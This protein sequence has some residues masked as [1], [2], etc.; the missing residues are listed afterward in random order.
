MRLHT[1]VIAAA[2]SSATASFAAERITVDQAVQMALKGTR[3]L[4]SV[5]K[6]AGWSHDIALSTGARLL[7]SVHLSEEFQH[8][9]CP[10]AFNLSNFAGG[11]EC[12]S[13]INAM[14]KA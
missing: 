13:T 8:W 3:R 1:F 12:L 11:A 4:A 2:V 6:R 14:P 10:A 9:D 7:P 5:E